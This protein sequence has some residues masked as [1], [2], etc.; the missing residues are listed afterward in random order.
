MSDRARVVQLLRPWIDREAG[1]TREDLPVVMLWAPRRSGVESLLNHLERRHEGHAPVASLSGTSLPRGYRPHEV[2]RELIWPLRKQLA[3]FRPLRFPRFLLGLAVITGPVDDHPDDDPAQLIEHVV[4]AVYH[5]HAALRGW[6]AGAARSIAEAAGA[7]QHAAEF[8]AQTVDAVFGWIRNAG[9]RRSPAF[10]WYGEG[11]G[12]SFL[13]PSR[14]L[15]QLARWEFGKEP[16][17]RR[18]DVALCRAFLADIRAEY[19]ATHRWHARDHNPLLLIHDAD[20]AAVTTLLDCLIEAGGP[21]PLAVVAAS[22]VRPQPGNHPH[23]DSPHDDDPHAWEPT[24]FGAASLA[25]W[26]RRR[27]AQSRWERRYP[28]VLGWEREPARHRPAFP[29]PERDGDTDVAFARRL[30]AGHPHAFERVL[31]IIG[32]AGF[33]LRT[34]FA[35]PNANNKP[36][37]EEILEWIFEAGPWDTRRA[38]VQMALL[39]DLQPERLAPII[40]DPLNHPEVV[41]R[42]HKS[43][44]WVARSTAGGAIRMHPFAR[45]ALAHLVG[46]TDVRAVSWQGWHEELR[47]EATA[48]PEGEV[49]ALYHRLALGEV[50]AVAAELSRMFAP[51]RARRWYEHELLEVTQAPLAQPAGGADAAERLVQLVQA[52]GDAEGTPFVPPRLVAALQ[53]HTDPLGDPHHQLCGVIETELTALSRSPHAGQASAY[54]VDCAKQFG[55]CSNRWNDGAER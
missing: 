14:A 34:V 12:E 47:K 50:H 22:N 18:V 8:V 38:V 23:D 40:R 6:L 39:R 46:R 37:D 4:N 16:Q 55:R 45:R 48:A 35:A 33:D 3:G 30:T 54:L 36:F 1:G 2:V 21:A 44:L 52:G 25:D 31:Q 42:Y 51:D 10:L 9:I 20:R 26:D 27:T 41:T 28:V 13:K 24:A 32:T 43:Q 15:E 49:T 17:R 11:L 53:L 7:G 19:E 5:D 29:A